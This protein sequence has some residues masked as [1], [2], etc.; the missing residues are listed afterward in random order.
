MLGTFQALHRGIRLLSSHLPKVT[1]ATW[2][3]VAGRTQAPGLLTVAAF[4][5]DSLVDHITLTH[6]T[7]ATSSLI[8]FFSCLIV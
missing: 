8:S 3:R 7:L 1:G 2:W 6:T 4:P 5:V